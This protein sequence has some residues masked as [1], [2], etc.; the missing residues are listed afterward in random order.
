[1]L[2]KEDIDKLA[3]LARLDI[4]EIEK[5]SL[6]KEIDAILGYVDEIQEVA[7]S[8][9]K[10]EAG[11]I[12]NVFRDDKEPHLPGEYTKELLEE[13]PRRQDNYVKVKKIL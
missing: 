10:K 7:G 11:E 12:R 5:E 13:A 6:R 2:K 4:P 3:A 1:M 8:E 9:G